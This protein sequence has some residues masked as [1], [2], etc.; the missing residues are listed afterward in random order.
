M[1]GTWTGVD[2]LGH[3]EQLVP[4]YLED[5]AALVGVDSGSHDAP[6]VAAAARWS[7]ERLRAADP[8]AELDV[9]TLPCEADGNPVG[10]AV[11]GLNGRSSRLDRVPVDAVS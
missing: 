5:L 10:D 9:A 3:F 11:G 4:G 2:L 1:A 8:G 6:G 7:V